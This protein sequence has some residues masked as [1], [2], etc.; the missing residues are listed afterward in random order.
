MRIFLVIKSL[1]RMF[2]KYLFFCLWAVLSSKYRWKGGRYH[3]L[4]R[5]CVATRNMHVRWHPLRADDL[6]IYRRFKNRLYSIGNDTV[7][8]RALA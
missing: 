8:K 7:R 6:E 4:F 2:W 5:F 3:N 1:L